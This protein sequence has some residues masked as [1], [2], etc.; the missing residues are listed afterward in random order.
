[1]GTL[2]IAKAVGVLVLVIDH[3]AQA[4]DFGSNI[5]RDIRSFVSASRRIHNYVILE[6]IRALLCHLSV[7][8]VSC[9]DSGKAMPSLAKRWTCPPFCIEGLGNSAGREEV[10]PCLVITGT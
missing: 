1:M 10:G 7:L 5:D 4:E 9:Y 3:Y 6:Q 8:Y 2:F